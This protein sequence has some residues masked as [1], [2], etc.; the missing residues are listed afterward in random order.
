M[1]AVS[2]VSASTAH[3]VAS[4]HRVTP[5]IR[6][7]SSSLYQIRAEPGGTTW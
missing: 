3:T 5:N 4:V 1:A 6:I 7:P 2:P